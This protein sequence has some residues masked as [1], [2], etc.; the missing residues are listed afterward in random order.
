MQYV[1]CIKRKH[2]VTVISLS[3]ITNLITMQKKKRILTYINCC[4]RPN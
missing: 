1:K 3:N 4:I 2:V